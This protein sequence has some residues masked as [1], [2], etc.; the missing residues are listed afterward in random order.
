MKS[1]QKEQVKGKKVLFTSSSA[2]YGNI[3]DTPRR[4]DMPVSLENPYAIDKFASER[5]AMFTKSLWYSNS[6][7]AFL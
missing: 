4:E 3:A 5:Y 1:F 2:V 7:C 6:C